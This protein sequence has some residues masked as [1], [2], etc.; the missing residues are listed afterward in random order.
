MIGSPYFSTGQHPFLS[1]PPRQISVSC[2]SIRLASNQNRFKFRRSSFG[3]ALRRPWPA[4]PSFS[5]L[6][7]YATSDLLSKT[8]NLL[9][10][11][12]GP[13]AETRGGGVHNFSQKSQ[14]WAGG[15]ESFNPLSGNLR[16]AVENANTRFENLE[17]KSGNSGAGI[18]NS[19]SKTENSGGGA[20]H[21]PSRSGNP[22]G[23]IEKCRPKASFLLKTSPWPLANRP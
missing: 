16:D 10:K 23:A 4:S 3:A 15:A 5:G 17:Y 2:Q 11:T 1:G 18:E 22:G 7:D 12:P 6:R 8:R 19:R 14:N 9:S 21:S 20:G 13:K